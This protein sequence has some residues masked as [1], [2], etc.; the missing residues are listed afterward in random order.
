AISGASL[1]DE[2]GD[3]SGRRPRAL[4]LGCAGERLSRD[5]SRFFA[6]ADPLGFVLFRRNCRSRD[7]VRELVAALR[8]AIGRTDAPVLIDQE[9]GRVARLQPPEWRS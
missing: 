2:T 1:R 9:G 4:I 3:P 8:G 5:E 7:Q 6:D